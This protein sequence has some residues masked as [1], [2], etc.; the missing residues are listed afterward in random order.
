MKRQASKPT[1][2][3]LVG[4]GSG[5]HLSPLISLSRAIRRAQPGWRVS[6]VGVVG[7]KMAKQTLDT[8]LVDDLKYLYG[9]KYRRYE[10]PNQAIGTR[11]WGRLADFSLNLRDFFLVTIGSLQAI[12]L[13]L[14][15]RPN[16]V[17]SKGGY[18]AFGP[19]LAAVVLKI[20]LVVHDSDA[21]PGYV[22]RFFGRWAK[23]RL[24]GV[25]TARSTD[26]YVGVPINPAFGQVM[27]GQARQQL[28][29]KY[30]L[31]A[32]GL[33][34]VATG[35]SL[36]ALNLN[37]GVLAVIDRLRYK[38]AV[39]FV[40][41]SGKAN[42]QEAQDLLKEVERRAKVTIL[43][44]VDDMPNLLRTA[45]IVI[46]RAGA[47]ALA[48]VAAAGKPAIVIPNPLLPG[49]HQVHNAQTYAQTKAALIVSD[50]GQQ[51][52]LRALLASLDKL[53][54]GARL[55]QEL[56]QA[57]RELAVVDATDQT[58]QSLAE[59]MIA[60]S[61][62]EQKKRYSRHLNLST[63]RQTLA[64]MMISRR[65]LNP[66]WWQQVGKGLLKLTGLGLFLGLIVW[67]LFAVSGIEVR[68][69]Q[70]SPLVAA[71]DLGQVEVSARSFIDDLSF[72]QRL[73]IPAGELQAALIDKHGFIDQVAVDKDLV[74]S[75]VLIGVT[76]KDIL[77][78][79]KTPSQT[80][81]LSTDGYV[82]EGY[83]VRSQAE[84]G[85]IIN[86]SQEL[87]LAGS[88]TLVLTPP[89][90]DFL[91]KTVAYLASAGEQVQSVEVDIPDHPYE[92]RFQLQSRGEGN[93]RDFHIMTSL[94]ADGLE[95]AAAIT[96]SLG[97]FDRTGDY[98]ED[99]LDVRLVT[100]VL[101]K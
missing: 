43:D 22:H 32:K 97:Y 52:N 55:R 30:G 8:T 93:K 84:A 14:R 58:F 3:S 86:S 76:P 83:Q 5:G 4:G 77:G 53:L 6:Y 18:P 12:W 70:Q 66:G 44:F 28:R 9:G 67:R 96:K 39:H 85:L 34:V 36:G 94:A 45:D 13:Y 95:Q 25:P 78:V 71:G 69:Q 46:T 35:G 26:R 87:R 38:R 89:E 72:W 19:C 40:V 47:T 1:H 49:A 20:P 81:I 99:Y 50:S 48:E 59:V 82:L 57:I 90:L 91:T 79:F 73:F 24:T 11:F 80:S 27:S 21:I 31:P 37:R 65:E 68:L 60:V 75:Q 61:P 29:Q 101:Y 51:V 42:H 64:Q 54:A 15:R 33:L 41:V 17:F 10:R 62:P 16:L 100:R 63:N 2:I 7:D 56:G 98:P 92:V 23:L 74:R 88:Q